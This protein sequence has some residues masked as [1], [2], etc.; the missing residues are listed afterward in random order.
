MPFVTVNVRPSPSIPFIVVSS[1]ERVVSAHVLSKLADAVESMPARIRLPK[2]YDQVIFPKAYMIAYE[3]SGAGVIVQ[4]IVGAKLS[5]L[6]TQPSPWC[7]TKGYWH[8][9]INVIIANA[10]R[11]AAETGSV[12]PGLEFER[13]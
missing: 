9:M 12:A 8:P 13:G 3:H 5:G 11:K 4:D 7:Y 2:K 1:S 6:T 10:L